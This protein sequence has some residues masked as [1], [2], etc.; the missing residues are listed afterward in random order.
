MRALIRKHP[1]KFTDVTYHGVG[2]E[3]VVRILPGE[4]WIRAEDGVRGHIV[5]FEGKPG[6]IRR[7]AGIC[8]WDRRWAVASMNENCH[9]DKE[10]EEVEV[11]YVAGHGLS[12]L[13]SMVA[14]ASLRRRG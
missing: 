6:V 11:E 2:A 9:A 3:E 8:A 4:G 5:V 1:Y 12:E 10:G 13:F 7:R 14:D